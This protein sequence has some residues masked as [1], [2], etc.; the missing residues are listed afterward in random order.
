MKYT[1][2]LIKI[3]LSIYK[4]RNY[5]LKSCDNYSHGIDDNDHVKIIVMIMMENFGKSWYFTADYAF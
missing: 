1:N 4:M 2:Y 5:F 3:A